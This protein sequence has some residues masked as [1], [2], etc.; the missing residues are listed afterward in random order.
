MFSLLDT[1]IKEKRKGERGT[2]GKEMP[3]EYITIYGIARMGHGGVTLE[4]NLNEVKE[5]AEE[6]R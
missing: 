5:L 2:E 1:N 4:Q 6:W 3:S